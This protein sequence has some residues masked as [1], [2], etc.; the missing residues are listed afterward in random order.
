MATYRVYN[1]AVLDDVETLG[2]GGVGGVRS[3]VHAVNLQGKHMVLKAYNSY[4]LGFRNDYLWFMTIKKSG[5]SGREGGGRGKVD[6]NAKT[7]KR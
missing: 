2:E 7:Q 6:R 4:N 1:L 5:S 3:I